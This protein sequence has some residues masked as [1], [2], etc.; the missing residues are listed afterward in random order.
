MIDDDHDTVELF[1]EYLQLKGIRVVGKGYNGQDAVALYQKLSP[2][3]VFLDAMM[4]YYDG[5][6][7]LEKIRELDPKAVVIMVTADLTLDTENRL[8]ELKA[9]DIIYKPYDINEVMSA[10][11]RSL[12]K[13]IPAS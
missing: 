12:R 2:D 6:Y 5:F 8:H 3:V 1:C 9:S 11:D 13:Q 7:G 10:V 4:P